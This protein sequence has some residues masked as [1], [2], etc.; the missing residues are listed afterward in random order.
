MSVREKRRYEKK[1]EKQGNRTKT[2][3]HEKCSSI[4]K[5]PAYNDD[6]EEIIASCDVWQRQFEGI[7]HIGHDQEIDVATMGWY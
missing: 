5:D 6:V 3:T 4:A 2:T 7:E 1:K